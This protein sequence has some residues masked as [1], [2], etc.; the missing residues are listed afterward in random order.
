MKKK[1]FNFIANKVSKY[2]QPLTEHGGIFEL[3]IGFLSIWW[4]NSWFVDRNV[5][6]LIF[7]FFGKDIFHFTLEGEP[8]PF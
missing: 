4:E 2:G 5:E 1:I 3:K 6:H 8:I 7:D